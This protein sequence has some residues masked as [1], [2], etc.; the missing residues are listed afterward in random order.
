[1]QLYCRQTKCTGIFCTNTKEMI[2][3]GLYIAWILWSLLRCS[4][5]NVEHKGR[6]RKL[7]GF[8]AGEWGMIVYGRES[9]YP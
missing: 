3:Y 7:P 1:M 2:N 9:E 6:D 4:P 8:R 5:E